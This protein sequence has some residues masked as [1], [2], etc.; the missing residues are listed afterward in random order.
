MRMVKVQQKLLG[1]FRS[2]SGAEMLY[3]IRGYLST[4]R[5]QGMSATDAIKIVLA[6]ELLSVDTSE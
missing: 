3:R 5:K 2:E 6:G 4:R 1:C